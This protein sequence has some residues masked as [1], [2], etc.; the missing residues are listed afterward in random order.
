GNDNSGFV[1]LTGLWKNKEK[2]Y[3][4]GKMGRSV[5]FVF[6]NKN[7][8]GE[9]DPEF[10]LCIAKARDTEEATEAKSDGDEKFGF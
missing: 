1:P 4:S 3:L 8:R 7:R 6:P 2:G 5:Y 9:N 10:N